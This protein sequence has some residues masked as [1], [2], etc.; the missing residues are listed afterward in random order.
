MFPYHDDK[1][2]AYSVHMAAS[3]AHWTGHR[4]TGAAHTPEQLAEMLY[5][6]PFALVSHGIQPDPVFCYANLAAQHLWNIS[7]ER[8]THLP[9]RMSAEPDAQAER[10]RLLDSCEEKGFVD[11]YHGVRVTSDGRRFNISNCVLWNVL[12]DTHGKIG[13]AASF[14][15]WEWL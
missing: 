3:Y 2:I 4:M 15:E 6:A 5:N 1:V 10:Q 9:S 13:Q 12:D 11:D 8:F 14:S 7:W